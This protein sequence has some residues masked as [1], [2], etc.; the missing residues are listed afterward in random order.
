VDVLRWQFDLTWRLFDLHL[1]LLTPDDFL[2]EPAAN[3]WTVRRRAGAWVPDWAEPEPDPL[4]VPAIAWLTWHI[5]WWWT[6]TIERLRG[7]TPPHR[8][9]VAWPGPG[10]PTIDWLRGLRSAWLDVLDGLTA[11]DAETAAWVN[12]ELMKNVAEIGQLRILRASCNPSTAA[13]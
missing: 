3:C 5:G 12:A 9:E 4:P 1:S 11:D 2:W 8:A 6:V 13:T 10:A 7:R